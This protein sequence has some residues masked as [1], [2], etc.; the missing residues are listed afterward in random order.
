M[1]KTEKPN[2]AFVNMAGG[3]KKWPPDDWDT[4]W[5][6]RDK[7]DDWHP[8]NKKCPKDSHKP[9][10]TGMRISF[11]KHCETKLIFDNWEWREDDR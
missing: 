10:D 3:D 8:A 11:C 2:R 5:Y 4:Y 1:T 7:S 9:A 6:A